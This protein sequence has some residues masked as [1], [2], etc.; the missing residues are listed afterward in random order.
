L[1]P[2]TTTHANAQ[3]SIRC[4]PVL[5]TGIAGVKVELDSRRAVARL[6]TAFCHTPSGRREGF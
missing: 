6:T 4:A 5:A 2:T 3:R 1:I